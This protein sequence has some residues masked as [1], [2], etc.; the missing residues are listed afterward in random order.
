MNSEQQKSKPEL[1]P[2]PVDGVQAVR[3]G[4]VIWAIGFLVCLVTRTQLQKHGINDAH[5]VCL[6]GVVLGLL[7]Q[8]YTRRRVNRLKLVRDIIHN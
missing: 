1:E 4:T 2:L 6:A 5:W 3:V 7:G 8:I